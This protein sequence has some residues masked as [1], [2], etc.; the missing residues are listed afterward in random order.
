MRDFFYRSHPSTGKKTFNN[1]HGSNQMIFLIVQRSKFN[2]CSFVL[3]V[4]RHVKTVRL[5]PHMCSRLKFGML[6]PTSTLTQV[7]YPFDY[8]EHAAIVV[9]DITKR[10]SFEKAK[11]F[12]DG[13]AQQGWPWPCVFV[14]LVGNKVDFEFSREVSFKVSNVIMFV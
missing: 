13:L 5:W 14:A 2:L 10:R 9:Y 4:H 6:W 3:L 12:V 11:K 8:S 7:P 1:G